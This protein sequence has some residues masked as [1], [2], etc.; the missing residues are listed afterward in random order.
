VTAPSSPITYTASFTT[1]YL[2]TTT[3]SPA[4]GGSIAASPTSGNGYY[5]IGASVQLTATANSGYQFTGWGGDLSGSGT[6][7]PQTIAMA[8]VHTVTANFTALTPVAVNT[9]P[10]G[11]A[12]VVDGNTVTTPQAF[13]WLPGSSHA[14]SVTSPQATGTG[15]RAAFS[16]WSDGGSQ[17]HSVTVPP[18]AIAYTANF[19]SQYLLTA[20][21]APT[22]GGAVAASPASTD[23]YYN[24]GVSVQLTAQPAATYQLVD[25]SGDLSGTTNPQTLTMSAPHNVVVKFAAPVAV[26]VATA[27]AGLAVIVDGATVTAPQIFNWLP[28][29]S[30]SLN[31]T[32]PQGTNPR[33]V[34][35]GWSDSG[36]ASHSI[37]APS[38]AATYT[39][40]FAAQYSL[41]TAVSPAGA[42]SV[43]ASPSSS[44]G[45]YASGT[46]VQLTAAAGSG[47]QFAG[48]SGD[49]S[50]AANPQSIAM[51]AA[52]S[53]TANFTVPASCSIS[54]APSAASLPATGTSTVAACPSG[55][56]QPNC[57][58]TPEVAR[59]FTVTPS[60]V[61][62]AWTAT[63]S[64]PG[65]LQI[66]SGGTASGPTRGAGTVGF[67]LLNNTH[68]GPQSYTITVA[69]GAASASYSVTE[70][71]SGDSEVYRQVFALYEQLLGR[72]P[73]PAGFAFWA[74]A[75]GAGLGQMADSFLTSPEA[76]NS[77]FA[78]MA[79]YQAAT[80]G[81]P[82]YAQ[83]TAAVTSVRAG[84]QTVT[85]LFNALI[86][87][88]YTAATLYQNLLN[89]QP[90]ASEISSANGAGLAAWFETL[91]GYPS[92]TTPVG[93]T[94]NEFQSTGTYH[95]TL[96]A[97]HTNGLY[98]QMIYY[99]TLSRDPDPAGLSFWTGIANGGGP[100]I[101]FQ[102]SAGYGTRIQILG[103][104]TP[105][106]GYI[107]S[108]EFQGLFAN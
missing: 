39:A 11:L 42:G 14:F 36:S 101:L 30:H 43:T 27:P 74:G 37:T 67:T 35:S 95:T 108:P 34:F 9:A 107:G 104:G 12:V 48:W 46:I 52:H 84:A 5:A 54:L 24:N 23:G 96:A 32:S 31:L 51:S 25:W 33:Y 68:S 66:T 7:N 76:F 69:S 79:A 56:G 106:Q 28:G 99:V 19:T 45:Y 49:L 80:G 103:P 20:T 41:S 57:G 21:A 53:V 3:P 60:A 47:Y 70:T 6:T 102:G 89:R 2:L 81:P 72:D 15:V 71:G 88:G 59:T 61:C 13:Q 8:A 87:S 98:V 93:A 85:G 44:D 64:S 82:T 4:A 75:G 94:N 77:D 97:D 55:S 73:D 78:V 92:N 17:S 91:I 65:F 1:E 29:S 38:A 58:F 16:S 26:T 40:T 83:F 62:G 63:S 22:A 105:N 90:T 86:G 10:S 50:G 100:G 18:S